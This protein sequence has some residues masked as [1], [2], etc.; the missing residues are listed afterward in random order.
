M[1]IKVTRTIGLRSRVKIDPVYIF[2]P[3]VIIDHGV[4]SFYLPALFNPLPRL[5][6]TLKKDALENT[7]GKEENAGDQHFLLFPQCFLV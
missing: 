4:K 5:L 2:E 3:P 1:L 7:V 6:T